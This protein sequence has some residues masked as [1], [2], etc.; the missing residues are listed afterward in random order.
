MVGSLFNLAP[1]FGRLGTPVKSG[2][3]AK[4]RLSEGYDSQTELLS[5]PDHALKRRVT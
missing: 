1:R 3:R 2:D 4:R 5:S